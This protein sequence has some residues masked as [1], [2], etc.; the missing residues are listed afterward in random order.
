ME[1][2][3]ALAEES[4]YIGLSLLYKPDYLIIQAENPVSPEAAAGGKGRTSKQDKENHGFGLRNIEY[5]VNKHS[6]FMLIEPE[7]G[8]FKISLALLVE[9]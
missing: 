4:R 9:P 8:V 3:A 2:C 5:L 6:G 7:P 1:A